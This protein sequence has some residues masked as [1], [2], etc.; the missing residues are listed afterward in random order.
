MDKLRTMILEFLSSKGM[1]G[2]FW[3]HP[4]KQ[5]DRLYINTPKSK[6][7][8]VWLCWPTSGKFFD[9]E[10][11][12]RAYMRD[13]AKAGMNTEDVKKIERDVW[14]KA[15]KAVLDPVKEMVETF[16]STSADNGGGADVGD[17]S[18]SLPF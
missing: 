14:I 5:D 3:S 1:R 7:M 10:M 8:S 9:G 18:D 12:L 11:K 15:A 4:S 13:E 6:D 17:E 16:N 2:E